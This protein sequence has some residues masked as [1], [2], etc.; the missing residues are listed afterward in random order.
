MRNTQSGKPKKSLQ[1]KGLITLGIGFLFNAVFVVLG[2]GG[3]LRELSRLATLIGLIMIIV[4]L[5]GKL[6]SKPKKS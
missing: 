5:V 1:V 3:L 2:V 4:G 6:F